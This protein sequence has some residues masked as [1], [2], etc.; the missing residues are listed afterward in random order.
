MHSFLQLP[1]NML[2]SLMSCGKILPFKQHIKERMNCIFSLM[3]L[4]IS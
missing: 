2:Q 3:L 1:V 4:S